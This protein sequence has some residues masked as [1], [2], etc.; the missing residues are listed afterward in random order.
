MPVLRKKM[1][2]IALNAIA[3]SLTGMSGFIGLQIH[4]TRKIA[5]HPQAILMLG[6][7][8]DREPYTAQFAQSRED[9][10]IW[11]SSGMPQSRSRQIFAAAGISSQRLYLDDRAVDTVTN[12]TTLVADL[13][14]QQIRH[15]YLLTSDFHMR[16]ASAIA[17]VVLGSQGII[18]TPVPIPSQQASESWWR[19]ARDSSRA[20]LWMFTG[21]TGASLNPR[22]PSS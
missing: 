2:A 6:G 3:L 12:F 4:Q 17:T 9:L 11:V 5:P 10:P 20:V 21:R 18:F 15:V 14:Q 1:L 22:L 8:F 13:K 7:D 16:R 19:V